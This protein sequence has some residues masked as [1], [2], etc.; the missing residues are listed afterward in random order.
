ME[1]KLIALRLESQQVEK[2]DRLIQETGLDQ[3]KIIRMLI[4]SAK[5]SPARVTVADLGAPKKGDALLAL[6]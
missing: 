3:S 4:D 6:G 2:L 1:G 5:I